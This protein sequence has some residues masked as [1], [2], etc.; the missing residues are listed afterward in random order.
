M[1]VKDSMIAA[2]ALT[3]N[4]TVATHNRNDFRKAKVKVVDPFA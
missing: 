2:T 1:P 4:L 3:H